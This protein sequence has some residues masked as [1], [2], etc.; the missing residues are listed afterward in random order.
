LEEKMTRANSILQE[1]G[2]TKHNSLTDDELLKVF[3]KNPK[4]LD[5]REE[6]EKRKLQDHPLIKGLWK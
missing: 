1:A 2:K 6:I 3:R 5:A 4:D